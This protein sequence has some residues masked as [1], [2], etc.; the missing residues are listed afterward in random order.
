MDDESCTK[1]YP[2]NFCDDTIIEANDFVRYRYR[3]DG[4][5][6][7]IRGKNIDNRWVVPYNLDLC[8]KYDAHINVERSA[9]QKVIKYLHKYMHKGPDRATN[10]IQD[11]VQNTN[12]GRDPHHYEVVDDIDQYLDCHYVSPI[13][14]ILR[15]FEF[16]ITYR[17]PSVELLQYYLPGQ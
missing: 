10:V 11:N 3:D 4:K 8:A 17:Y 9:Q 7:T 6:V 12:N 15:I 16:D 5:S 13:D 2:T 1:H 14:A